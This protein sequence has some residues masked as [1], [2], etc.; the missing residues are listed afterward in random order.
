MQR[1]IPPHTHAFQQKHFQGYPLPMAEFTCETKI[2]V[3]GHLGLK[4]QKE[5]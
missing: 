4:H 3:G 2:Q 5:V 1:Q